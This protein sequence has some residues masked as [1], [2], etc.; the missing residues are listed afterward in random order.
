[1]IS[2]AGN[3]PMTS[4]GSTNSTWMRFQSTL[5]DLM[6]TIPFGVVYEVGFLCLRPHILGGYVVDS[7]RWYTMV[8]GPCDLDDALFA[9]GMD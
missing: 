8:V 6:Y 2:S 1:M 9:H 3:F 4:L 7:S 5:V